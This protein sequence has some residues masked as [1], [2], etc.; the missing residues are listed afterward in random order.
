MRPD[1]CGGVTREDDW[2]EGVRRLSAYHGR[3]AA[4]RRGRVLRAAD[5]PYAELVGLLVGE[6]PGAVNG[7][8]RG[9]PW[10]TVFPGASA[11][12]VAASP[13]RA[14]VLCWPPH[15]DDSASY[16]ALRAFRGDTLVYVGEGPGGPAGTVRFPGN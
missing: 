2:R 5:N 9:R 7:Y 11:A 6:R 16:A 14:L 4:A 12:A 13:G 15:D 8:H 10:T 1:L 3:L